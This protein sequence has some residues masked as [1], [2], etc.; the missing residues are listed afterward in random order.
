MSARFASRKVPVYPRPRLL[1]FS[2]LSCWVEEGCVHVAALL[3]IVENLQTRRI[4]KSVHRADVK[5]WTVASIH[6]PRLHYL[7]PYLKSPAPLTLQVN[8]SD[9]R[10]SCIVSTVQYREHIVR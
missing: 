8:P 9:A 4:K 6:P 3:Q 2:C 5:Q 1:L 10:S 7:M